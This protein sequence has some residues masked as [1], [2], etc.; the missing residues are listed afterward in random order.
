MGTWAL[1]D[2]PWEHFEV[3][4][5]DPEIIAAVK[6]ASMVEYN[7][8]DYRRYLTNVF[9][10]D[11][12]I[13]AAINQWSVEEVQH[14]EALGRWATLADPTF[15]FK[16][17]FK[18]FIGNFQFPLDVSVSTRGSRAGELIAR[19]MVETGTNSFYSALADAT[20]EPVLKAICSRIADDEYAHYCL[21]YA[22]MKRYLS[23]ED[24]S[25][26]QRLRIA[27]SRIAETEDEELASAYWAANRPGDIFDR[28]SNS[29]AYAQATLKYYKSTHISRGIEMIFGAMG[30]L[31]MAYAAAYFVGWRYAVRRHLYGIEAGFSRLSGYVF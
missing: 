8:D 21:F 3:S 13:C 1:T 15:D 19:C 30:K 18:R 10:D 29:V 16:G 20:E 6:A 24:L 23:K 9:R 26:I 4:K 17:S 28:R 7:A 2:I 22:Y 11:E 5:V 27:F 31:N 12:R 14:G 25:F